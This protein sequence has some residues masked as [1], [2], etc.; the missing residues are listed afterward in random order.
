MVYTDYRPTPLQHF[1]FPAGA[2][3]LYCVL[4]ERGTFHEDSFQKAIAALTDNNP[5][6][7]AGGIF[8]ILDSD[9][10]YFC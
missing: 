6:L 2:E 1:L 9:G 8:S 7:D 5:P 10:R 3:G 4:D